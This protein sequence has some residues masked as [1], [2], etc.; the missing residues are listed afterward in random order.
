MHGDG[1][2]DVAG[3]AVEG[4]ADGEFVGAFGFEDEVFLAL[5][6]DGGVGQFFEA[7]AGMRIFGGDGFVAE[8]EGDAVFTGLADDAGE[9]HGGGL[10]GEVGGVFVAV[11]EVPQ[12][13]G[14]GAEGAVWVRG[15]KA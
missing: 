1:G 11:A 13:G 4:L 10:E 5:H 3:D 8:V 2:A 9:E 7:D 12:D 14:A 15:M 6:D